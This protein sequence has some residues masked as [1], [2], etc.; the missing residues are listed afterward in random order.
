M[1]AAE[2][3]HI[4][5]HDVWRRYGRG[6]SGF[7]AVRGVSFTVR[8]GSLFALLGTNGAG[9]TSTVELLEGLAAPHRG[10][11]R[12]FGNLDPVAD[13]ARIR[14][15]T[16]AMLQEGGFIAHLT[17]RESIEMWAELTSRPRPVRQ[18]LEL[19]GLSH[20][21]DVLVKNLSGGEKRGPG[22]R[23]SLRPRGALPRR[24]DRRHGRRRP[25]RHLAVDP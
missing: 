13:R 22:H 18:A 4:H 1:A 10:Q 15:R 16:G 23:H 9:K 14:A 25:A 12:L 21:A 24:T 7:M 5:A 19:A 11:I 20:R 2:S 17:A 3:S 6:K 8:P